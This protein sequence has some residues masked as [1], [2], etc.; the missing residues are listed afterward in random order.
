MLE[1]TGKKEKSVRDDVGHERRDFGRRL[2]HVARSG[3]S[4]EILAFGQNGR[5]V[6][7]QASLRGDRP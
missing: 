2:P 7:A 5:A 3:G 1:C 4:R 6:I